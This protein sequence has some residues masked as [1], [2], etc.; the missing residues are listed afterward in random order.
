M[1]K[2]ILCGLLCLPLFTGCAF[3]DCLKKPD[4]Q[5]PPTRVINI[6]PKLLQACAT[7]NKQPVATVEDVLLE[8]IDL[9]GQYALCARKQDDSV[10]ALKEI[11]NIK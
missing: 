10:R 1:K 3:L 7:L 8:N 5:I 2:L 9:Y 6:D 11:G 4:P